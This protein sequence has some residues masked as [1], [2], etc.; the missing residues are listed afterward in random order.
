MLMAKVRQATGREV[1]T[2][3]FAL[4]FS[5]PTIA[6][7]A[8]AMEELAPAEAPAEESIPRAHFSPGELAAGVP[9]TPDQQRLLRH[10]DPRASSPETHM[11][12]AVRLQGD[13]DLAALEAALAAVAQ[14]HDALRM[15]FV[16]QPGASFAQALL[17]P[18]GASF[19]QALL[20]PDAG[21]AAAR[22]HRATLPAAADVGGA[23]QQRA[24]APFDL[25]NGSAPWRAVLYSGA[26]QGRDSQHV[27][28]LVAHQALCDQW[29]LA[30]LVAEVEAAYMAQK[31]AGAQATLPQLRLQLVDVAAWQTRQLASGA[32]ATEQAFWRQQLAY[33]PLRLDLPADRP[34]PLKLDR[35]AACVEAASP[36]G[37]ASRLGA[38]AASCN[39]TLFM[40]V[41]AAWK[42]QTSITHAEDAVSWSTV[43]L[44][45]SHG[46]MP[47]L[48]AKASPP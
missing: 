39:A 26:A 13:L 6:G 7:L 35:R 46:S 11:A 29:S 8:E 5:R 1:P 42:V 23:L 16:E 33:A 30:L 41:L 22:L 44:G 19:A 31:G 2:S 14:R 17:S 12:E 25:L 20:S 24:A 9:C 47:I 43:I 45:H 32:W 48:A 15:H 18:E 38:L 21:A 40:V 28:L 3:L 27:L 37:L 34:R 4:F 36:E 10:G